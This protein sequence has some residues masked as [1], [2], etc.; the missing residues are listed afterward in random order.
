MRV[1]RRAWG[2]GA[3]G[4]AGACPGAAEQGAWG[5]GAGGGAGA[6]P[7]AARRGL[8]PGREAAGVAGARAGA[9]FLL[10]LAGRLAFTDVSDEQTS[11]W[12]SA[13][14]V[15]GRSSGFA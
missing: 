4:G 8:L 3:G 13:S 15:T 2:A 1:E 12:P 10:F 11:I 14:G 6:C 5:T 7:E 9:P